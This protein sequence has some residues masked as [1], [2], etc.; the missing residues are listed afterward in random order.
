M[1]EDELQHGAGD[2]AMH[3]RLGRLG[4]VPVDT[5]ALDAAIRREIG[6]R[7]SSGVDPTA[8]RWASGRRRW[9]KGIRTHRAVAA[10]FG[11][12]VILCGIVFLTWGTSAS[13]DASAMMLRVHEDLVSGRVQ[14]VQVDSIGEA[15]R[16]LRER[17]PA[18]PGVPNV[19]AEHVMK[20]CM[21]DEGDRRLACVLM[22]V[23][24]T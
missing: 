18:G 16:A 6:G 20:C 21:R 19:P 2:E 5:A 9:W 10:S 11:A 1:N 12:I 22:E 17:W 23:D 24:G 13:A 3:R 7:P 15:N 14:A 4:S 8:E